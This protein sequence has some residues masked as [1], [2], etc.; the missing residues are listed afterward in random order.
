MNYQL[1]CSLAERLEQTNL[2][3]LDA[4]TRLARMQKHV[5]RIRIELR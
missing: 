2:K 5:E 1:A 3:L 4:Q